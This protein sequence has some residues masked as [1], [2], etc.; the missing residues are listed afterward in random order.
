MTESVHFTVVSFDFLQTKMQY[1]LEALDVGQW[2]DDHFQPTLTIVDISSKLPIAYIQ[3]EE[4]LTDEIKQNCAN[5]FARFFERSHLS[6]P[7]YLFTPSKQ[8]RHSINIFQLSKE[9]KWDEINRTQFPTYQ[10]FLDYAKKSR[11]RS[12]ENETPDVV[13]ARPQNI[14]S[15]RKYSVFISSTFLDLKTERQEALHSILALQHFP[16]GMELFPAS[17]DDSLTLIKK[18]IDE[19]D[20]Y[21]LIVGGRYGSIHESGISFTEFEY[22]YAMNKKIPIL[23]FLLEPID[24]LPPDKKEQNPKSIVKLHKFRNRIRNELN[25]IFWS[26]TNE[27]QKYIMAS[28]VQTFQSHPRAGWIRNGS[29]LLHDHAFHSDRSA[30]RTYSVSIVLS[31]DEER[32]LLEMVKMEEKGMP[33]EL[34]NRLSMSETKTRHLLDKL[35]AE[36]YLSDNIDYEDNY[37]FYFTEKARAYLVKR[38][39]IN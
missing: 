30:Q 24:N 22:N 39:L 36:N 33:E 11:S 9:N 35:K 25:C 32:I 2:A 29:V 19:C 13:K 20:Y 34:A 17:P 21:I 26:Q 5:A 38:G 16:S 12:L 15:H 28:L 10:M 14:N 7:S 18:V 4:N 31:D 6:F 27:L 1:P 8:D 23:S 3:F 37:F